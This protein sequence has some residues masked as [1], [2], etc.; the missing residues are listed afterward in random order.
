[1]RY[2]SGGKYGG[3]ISTTEPDCERLEFDVWVSVAGPSSTGRTTRVE[4]GAGELLDDEGGV[5]FCSGGVRVRSFDDT[6]DDELEESLVEV[7][8]ALLEA[9]T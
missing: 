1:M 9:T 3:H 5:L 8:E 4:D 6:S 2:D 7:T